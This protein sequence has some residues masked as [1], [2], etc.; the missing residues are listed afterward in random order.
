MYERDGYK[1]QIEE[2]Q[3]KCEDKKDRVDKEREKFIEFKKHVA[4]NAINSRSGKP[5]PQKV[6]II[7]LIT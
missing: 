1:Q 5:I 3:V 4:L 7:S 6:F 2:L